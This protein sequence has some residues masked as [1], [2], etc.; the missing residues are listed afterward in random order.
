MYYVFKEGNYIIDGE[1]LSVEQKAKAVV[2]EELP[3]PEPP[4]GKM[5]VLRAD[6]KAGTV[7]YEYLDIPPA[8]AEMSEIQNRVT[9]LEQELSKLKTDTQKL[10]DDV[11]LLKV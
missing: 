5:A 10:T 4:Y 11:S 1:D 9:Q 8:T 7:F 2:V 3:V 6:T